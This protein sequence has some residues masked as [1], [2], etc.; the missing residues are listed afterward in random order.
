MQANLNSVQTKRLDRMGQ[1]DLLAANGETTVDHLFG[2]VA[3]VDRT[4]K[5]S[6]F[7]S[8]TNQNDTEAIKLFANLF[9]FTPK[10]QVIGFQLGALR[11]KMFAIV[12]GGAQ[13]FAFWQQKVAGVSGFNRDHIAHLA[14]FLD[15]FQKN[16]FHIA[17]LARK[18]GA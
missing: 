17:L 8:L 6:G 12:F 5:L 18:S 4:I 7:T 10:L 3:G 16:D 1:F 9:G 14:E 2:N 11:F 13:G 15:A